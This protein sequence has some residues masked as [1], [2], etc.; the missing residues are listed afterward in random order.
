MSI[1]FNP[2]YLIIINSLGKACADV[3]WA[4]AAMTMCKNKKA[5]SQTENDDAYPESTDYAA[6]RTFAKTVPL[7]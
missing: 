1:E 4:Y 2:R 7:I 3:C 5:A 6:Q